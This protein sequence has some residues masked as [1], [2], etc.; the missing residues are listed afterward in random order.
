[1]GD[2]ANMA[3]ANAKSMCEA[4]RSG[5]DRGPAGPRNE[6]GAL[7]G[8]SP[9]SD[10]SRG[11]MLEFRRGLVTFPRVDADPTPLLHKLA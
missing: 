10:N 2:A 8:G 4:M 3:T 5:A 7:E 11:A 6:E 1:M 9:R